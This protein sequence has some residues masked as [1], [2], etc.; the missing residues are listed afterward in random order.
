MTV[1]LRL[2]GQRVH[3]VAVD[4]GSGEHA[5]GRGA[6]LAGVEVARDRDV[7]RGRGDVD[8]IEDDDRRLATELEVHALQGLGGT[9]G[10]LHA[11][12]YRTGHRH[13]GRNRVLDERTTGVAVAA[14]DVEDARG[15]DLGHQ[16]GHQAPIEAGVES[17]GLRTIVFPAAI[18]G[19]HFHTA[20]II[21]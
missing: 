14:D 17:P 3:E 7:L 5:R 2:L 11:G 10:D 20:I 12:A 4:L 18:A 16:L 8:V 6:V 1:F 15:Q 21:G 9:G 19:A 13:H